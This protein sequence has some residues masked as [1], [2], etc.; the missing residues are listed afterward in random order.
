MSNTSIGV[1]EDLNEYLVAHGVREPDILR[2]LREE[3][4]ALPQHDMQIAPEQGAFMALLVEILDAR[5]C[6]ELGTFTGY[7]SLVVAL[8]MPSDG[9]IVCC[10]VS[11]EWT[12][13]ARRYWAEAGVGD[14]VDLRLGPALETLD[15]LLAG[16]AA[17]TFDFAFVDA[18]KRE[19]PDYHERIVRL[20][21]QGGLVVYDNVLWAGDIL[22]E[23][24]TDPDT[25]GVRRLNDRIAQDERVTISMIPVADGLTL[26]RKR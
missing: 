20:L 3:T 6:I 7:S 4:A 9:R 2:R 18:S 16:G 5:R 14:R 21:R 17:G 23:S 8:A 19:Y 22:D 15:E 12:S 10:D 26:A 1:P 25:L 24:K 13:I 11:E